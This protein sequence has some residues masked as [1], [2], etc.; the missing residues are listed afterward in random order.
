MK[1]YLVACLHANR[2]FPITHF[3]DAEDKESAIREFMTWHGIHH[4]WRKAYNVTV[5]EMI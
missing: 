4:A 3:V 5:Y 1:R 2:E